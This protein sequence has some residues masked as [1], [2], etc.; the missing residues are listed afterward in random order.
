MAAIDQPPTRQCTR[1]KKDGSRCGLKTTRA[2]GWCRTCEGYG[3]PAQP[4]REPELQQ[5][6]L[7]REVS[8]RPLESDEAY[9]IPISNAA[10][11]H[12][13]AAHG[14]DRLAAE[15]QIRSLL[16]DLLTGDG[17][18]AL[19]HPETGRWRLRTRRDKFSIT[20]S[21]DASL[22]TGYK[23]R[24]AERTYA[25][26]KAGVPSR[27][28]S[29]RRRE[30]KKWFLALQTELPFGL[31]FMTARQ[32]ARH[33]LKVEM[34]QANAAEVIKQVWSYMTRAGISLPTQEGESRFTD[35]A[36]LLWTFEV[37]PGHRPYLLRISWETEE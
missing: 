15:V 12:F 30:K 10:L 27:T 23:S 3:R 20:L 35:S 8:A 9:R 21:E 22:V 11:A 33:E 25:Q 36:G 34:T 4:Q 26:V 13:I 16:E 17:P 29:P 37:L 19:R 31:G 24:H 7:W 1:Y 5:V 18:P 14:G 28:A 6:T 32:F 2:D